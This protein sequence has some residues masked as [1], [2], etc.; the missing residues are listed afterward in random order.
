MMD[1]GQPVALLTLIAPPSLS[2]ELI[3]WLLEY[4]DGGFSSYRGRGHGGPEHKLSIAE[5][6][7]GGQSAD[8]YQVHCATEQVERL[9]DALV[10]EFQGAGLH[11]W[12][13]PV[14]A[15]GHV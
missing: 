2:H 3:D 11:Y 8:V 9:V 5:Q 7:A 13:T 4:T 10:E 15:S 1:W 6:V 12:V 14:L